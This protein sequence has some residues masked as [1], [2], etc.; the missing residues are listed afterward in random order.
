MQP[1]EIKKLLINKGYLID[2][3]QPSHY[4]SKLFTG[5]VP[6]VKKSKNI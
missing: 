4:I 6:L 2:F 3:N 5:E 1:E